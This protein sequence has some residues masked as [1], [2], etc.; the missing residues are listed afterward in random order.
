LRCSV[1][2]RGSLRPDGF[3]AGTLQIVGELFRVAARKSADTSIGPQSFTP[4]SGF[5]GF[6]IG[7]DRSVTGRAS[8]PVGCTK[9]VRSR[10]AAF[11]YYVL[12]SKL[13]RAAGSNS[14]TGFRASASHSDLQPHMWGFLVPVFA[15]ALVMSSAGE[16]VMLQPLVSSWWLG[17]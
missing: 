5:G 17:R 11:L 12:D 4:G 6:R 8:A 7:G 2:A 16:S 1:I 10:D 13:R 3:R 15:G 9:N 14:A